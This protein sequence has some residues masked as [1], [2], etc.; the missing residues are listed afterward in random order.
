MIEAE[1]YCISFS[2]PL[3]YQT[4]TSM[5]LSNILLELNVQQP[6]VLDS[7]FLFSLLPS[8]DLAGLHARTHFPSVITFRSFLSLVYQ[9]E[10]GSGH[11]RTTTLLLDLDVATGADVRRISIGFEPDTGG[12]PKTV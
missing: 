3:S 2:P 4:G 9:A 8:L 11:E 7:S 10:G 1:D 12:R 5:S 6:S